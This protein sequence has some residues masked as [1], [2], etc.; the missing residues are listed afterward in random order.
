[1]GL[2]KWFGGFQPKYPGD[3]E[4]REVNFGYVAR[5]GKEDI[6]INK[7]NIISPFDMILKDTFVT[8]EVHFDEKKSR[9][10]AKKIRALEEENDSL[11]KL[12]EIIDRNSDFKL[13]ALKLYLNKVDD[14][15]VDKYLNDFIKS[16]YDFN[17]KKKFV[18]NLPIKYLARYSELREYL[19]IIDRIEVCLKII[20]DTKALDIK[21]SI[22]SEALDCIKRLDPISQFR[23]RAQL[24]HQHPRI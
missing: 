9:F 10:K 3:D 17:I 4:K 15:T 2:V 1:M 18:S 23:M 12:K 11:I 21:E 16:N 5:E 19:E 8:F 13:P 20:E 6:R 24:H 22:A 7:E 14:A